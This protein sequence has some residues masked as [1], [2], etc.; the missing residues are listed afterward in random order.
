M[1]DLHEV[2]AKSMPL[3]GGYGPSRSEACAGRASEG[4]AGLLTVSQSRRVAIRSSNGAVLSASGWLSPQSPID[5]GCI[6]W[7]F[8]AGF[9]KNL[10]AA[11]LYFSNACLVVALPSWP[12][13]WT[14]ASALLG[15]VGLVK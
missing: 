3:K 1:K 9:V 6:G 4:I 8:A 13:A 11:S 14:G 2:T 5:L 7:Y 12:G 10:K 15:H